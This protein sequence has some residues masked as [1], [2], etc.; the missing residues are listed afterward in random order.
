MSLMAFSTPQ[1]MDFFDKIIGQ[2][3]A[4]KRKYPHLPMV[5]ELL[6]RNEAY[7]QRYFRWLNE[8]LHQA[9]TFEIWEA[10]QRKKQKELADFVIH[11][12]QHNGA[13]GFAISYHPRMGENE[14]QY[15]FDWL[16]DRTL[17]LGYK[18]YTS[19]R[20]IFDRETYVETI[21]KH[22]LKPPISLEM[23]GAKLKK[24]CDQQYGNILVEY[25]LVD[26]QPS[27]IRFMANYYEDHLYTKVLHF[28]DLVNQVLT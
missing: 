16:K 8:G 25:V 2:I 17:Q 11:L 14:F 18:H 13:N 24:L 26:G 3:F 27:F 21:E 15:F 28:D 19:D 4:T 12:L 5:E 1:W 20:R 9:L 6:E 23:E 22:Y 7:R 10:W